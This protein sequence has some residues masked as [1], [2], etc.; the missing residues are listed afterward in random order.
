MKLNGYRLDL[1]KMKDGRV[2]WKRETPH[3]FLILEGQTWIP[4][5]KDVLVE[6]ITEAV[7]LGEEDILEIVVKNSC[8]QILEEGSQSGSKSPPPLI[9]L[10]GM[11]LNELFN[12]MPKGTKLVGIGDRKVKARGRSGSEHEP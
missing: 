8:Y 2:I 5:K 4:L 6:L 9:D 3:R 12:S 10:E 11:P 1:W 7:Q